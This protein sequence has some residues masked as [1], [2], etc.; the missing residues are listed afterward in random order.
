MLRDRRKPIV[1]A[2]S[3][4]KSVAPALVDRIDL[5]P[6]VRH[7]DLYAIQDELIRSPILILD[8]VFSESLSITPTE[9]RVLLRNGWTIAGASS[10]GALRA[11]DLWPEGMIGIGDI[12]LGFRT[13]LLKSDAE[14]AVGLHPANYSEVTISGVFLRAAISNLIDQ[15]IVDFTV[16]RKML[17]RALNLHFLERTVDRC[18]VAW[19]EQ[20]ISKAVVLSCQT[21]LRNSLNN[22]KLAD[23]E[24]ALSHILAQ[25]WPTKGTPRIEQH[26]LPTHSA[27]PKPDT[28]QV[29]LSCEQR[30]PAC[31][32][33]MPAEAIFCPSCASDTHE[34]Q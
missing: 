23:A 31:A 20:G 6:P 24:L 29:I 34:N 21:Y 3:S 1:F 25:I 33:P 16:G 27:V 28:G 4:I 10:M 12:Y 30:C 8:G 22:P 19:D 9:C 7:G 11:A 13:G 5:R 17:V 2:G 26:L 15:G 14:V 18:S 32:S